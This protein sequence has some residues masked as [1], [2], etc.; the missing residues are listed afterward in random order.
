MKCATCS[1][2]LEQS[3]D[4]FELQEGILGTH[5]LVPI[6]NALL[7]CCVQCLKDF[8]NGSRGYIH[9]ARRIA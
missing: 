7:F 6:G 5:G 4:A 8:F 2:E 3:M 9:K 1:R